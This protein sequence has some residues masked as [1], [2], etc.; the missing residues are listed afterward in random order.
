[1]AGHENYNI[2]IV[3]CIDGTGSMSPIIDEVK[4]NALNFYPNLE[5]AMT[6][7]KKA[8][9]TVRMKC[10]VFRDYQCDEEPMRESPFFV[11]P[12]QAEE[13]QTFVN[14]ITA[15]GG[16]DIPENALEAIA[17]ALKSDWT[18]EGGENRRHVIV[19]FTDAPALSLGERADCP[20]Y[21]TDLPKSLEELQAWWEGTSEEFSGTYQRD[22][23]RLIVFAPDDETWAQLKPWDRCRLFSTGWGCA[24]VD[25]ETVIDKLTETV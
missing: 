24:D 2:D 9:G 1:M 25:T 5:G 22:A 16:G 20:N 6:D 13:L 14:S 18:T 23:G 15:N 11:L 3:M 21:P 10:I 8:T 7:A 17:T 12:D 4:K 19:V